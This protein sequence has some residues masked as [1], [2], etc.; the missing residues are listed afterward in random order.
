MISLTR[1]LFLARA[2]A[3]GRFTPNGACDHARK[4]LVK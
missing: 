4:H 2:P 1:A 3:L